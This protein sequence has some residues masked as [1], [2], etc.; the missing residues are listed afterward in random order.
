MIAM[1]CRSLG[2]FETHWLTSLMTSSLPKPS[3]TSTTTAQSKKSK[4]E[5]SS[6][7]TQVKTTKAEI[8]SLENAIKVKT[9]L[10]ALT[11]T[12][13]ASLDKSAEN[14]KPL[15][16]SIK[17]WT[18]QI[19]AWNKEIKILEKRLKAEQVDVTKAKKGFNRS[20][21]ADTTAKTITTTPS[22]AKD[23][24]TTTAADPLKKGA[25]TSSSKSAT[26]KSIT[27]TAAP[28]NTTAA[29]DSTSV[30][31][32]AEADF[33]KR[34]YNK[35][36]YGTAIDILIAKDDAISVQTFQNVRSRSG[37]VETQWGVTLTHADGSVTEY[38]VTGEDPTEMLNDK[39]TLAGTDASGTAKVSVH[40]GDGPD[41]K[42]SPSDLE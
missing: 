20:M 13:V 6:A 40:H 10:I 32:Q 3:N 2:L 34:N 23:T 38:L 1:R 29:N 37:K 36:A 4:T 12:Q 28:A 33:I 31:P 5:V 8:D 17:V 19:K 16:D 9:D 15:Q 27:T 18:G 21:V 39:L 26:P 14:K 24:T 30:R 22:I 35:H 25:G 11:K 7:K 42:L 41:G